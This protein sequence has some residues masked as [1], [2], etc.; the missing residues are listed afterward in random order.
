MFSREKCLPA[1]AGILFATTF[2]WWCEVRQ[3][4]FSAR[5]SEQVRL[6]RGGSIAQPQRGSPMS[7]QCLVTAIS[8]A[9]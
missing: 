6:K 1:S 9:K 3:T 5:F 4:F 8:A 2:T 7:A